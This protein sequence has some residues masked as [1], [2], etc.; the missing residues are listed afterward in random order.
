MT[1]TVIK[2]GNS[3]GVTIPKN[4]LTQLKLKPGSKVVVEPDSM[5]GIVVRKKGAV[6][7]SSI[8]PGFV[9]IVNRVNK[10]YASSFR[11]LAKK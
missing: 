5:G 8:T 3:A 2:I 9:D 7:K 1:Q 6:G 4:I 10:R 11:E